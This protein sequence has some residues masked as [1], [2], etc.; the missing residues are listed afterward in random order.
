MKS[1]IEHEVIYLLAVVD[2][3]KSMVNREMFDVLGT[4]CHQN[5]LFRTMT[6][7]RFFAIALVDFLSK[8]D[9]KVEAPVQPKAFLRAVRDISTQPSFDVNGSVNDLKLA[10]ESFAS[11]LETEM[12]V[13]VWLPSIN[14]Q[15]V[16]RLTRWSL[17]CIAGNLSKHNFLRSV[18][19][20]MDLKELLAKAD[21][22]VEMHDVIL[23]Q[24]DIYEH[25]HND[26]GLYHSSAIAEHLNNILWGIQTYLLPEFRRS[27]THDQT[28]YYRYAYQYPDGLK[29]PLSQACYW[30][31]MNHIRSGP[32]FEP[33]IISE[34]FKSRY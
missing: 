9:G 25:F 17:H 21:A 11:W 3:I 24:N 18:G 31:L 28:E 32:I 10:A 8:T 30:D 16:L 23:V 14:K 4:Q 34:S 33:F 5:I 19:I 7:H 20:A 13:D 26:V 29:D 2:L 15:V 12:E 27:Y 22:P 1:N 6:H